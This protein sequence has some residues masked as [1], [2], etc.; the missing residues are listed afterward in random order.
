MIRSFK[1][2]SAMTG[3]LVTVI[4]TMVLTSNSTLL[5]EQTSAINIIAG[6]IAGVI[7]FIESRV[8][9]AAIGVGLL[10]LMGLIRVHD[11]IE[12]GAFDVFGFL[13][14]MMCVI[15]YLHVNH[16]FKWL[17]DHIISIDILSK[18]GWRLIMVMMTASAILAALVDEATSILV[19]L[20]VQAELMRNANI[21]RIPFILM[22]VF[23]TNIGS[24]AT[25]IGNPVGVLIA[26]KAGLSADAFLVNATP[27]SAIALIICLGVCGWLFRR[28]ISEFDGFI[29][30]RRGQNRLDEI[31]ITEDEIITRRNA[32]AK[33]SVL[34]ALTII[35]LMSHK[36][37][38][39][40][41]GLEENTMLLGTALLAGGSALFLA[42]KEA[43]NIVEHHIEW[44]ALS[45]FFLIFASVGGLI[46]AGVHTVVGQN[47]ASLTEGNET[48]MVIVFIWTTAI[49]SAL[50]DNVLA[51]A[52]FIP[53]IQGL[54][55]TGIG[56]E[57]LWW[58]T[59]FGATL[60]GNAT[61]IGSTANI[62][63][64]AQIEK[65][66]GISFLGW[67]R[68]GIPITLLTLIPAMVLLLFW[69]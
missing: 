63:A 57:V 26:I 34:F 33:S 11:F 18:N 17:I 59:L 48:M 55:D 36:M 46:T 52:T 40:S 51:V 28:P 8:A 16:F 65:A 4:V 66:G 19:M 14:G 38:E 3:W 44:W 37:I 49:F 29:R 39:K 10:M 30:S 27:I 23:A 50:L 64:L 35:G 60:G 47:I 67:M 62:V 2:N 53:V 41:L 58:A 25:A 20:A 69:H 45:F 9:F 56:G 1:L 22:L 15:G 12:H 68:Y 42:G 6:V 54:I 7:F 13:F 21:N 61:V 31:T 24:S 32:V 43:Q 5:V